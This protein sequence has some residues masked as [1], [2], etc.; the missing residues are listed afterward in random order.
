MGDGFPVRIQRIAAGQP[1]RFQARSAGRVRAALSLWEPRSDK[2]K[3]VVVE[4]IEARRKSFPH[5]FELGACRGQIAV[6]VQHGVDVRWIPAPAGL[7][8]R[9]GIQRILPTCG[10]DP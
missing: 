5:A 4:I 2:D 6:E 8:R 9:V 7:V 1:E 3:R 10:R